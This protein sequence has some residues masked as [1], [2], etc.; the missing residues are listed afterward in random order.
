MSLVSLRHVLPIVSELCKKWQY[1]TGEELTVEYFDDAYAKCLF[2]L[3]TLL[4]SRGNYLED[5]SIFW[6]RLDI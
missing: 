5:L 1:S 3:G 2:D 4:E 6:I